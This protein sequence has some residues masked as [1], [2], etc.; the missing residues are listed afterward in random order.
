MI[1]KIVL[2]I[3]LGVISWGC[4]VS[5]TFSGASI[6]PDVK[7]CSVAYFNNMAAMVAPML[8]PT[9]TDRL[10]QKI[11]NQTRLQIVREDGDVSFEGE[12]VDYSTAPIAISGDEYAMK[13]RLTIRVKV[14]FVNKKEPKL[15]YDKTFSSYADYDTSQMLI[16]IESTLIPE[17]VDKLVDNIFNDAFSNW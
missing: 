4:K 14:R 15:S 2:L 13:N 12:I 10:T 8:S 3:V 11:Q 1:K 7:S 9:L 6:S 17:I 5:Y 16:S